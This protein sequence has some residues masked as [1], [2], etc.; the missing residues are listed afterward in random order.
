MAMIEEAMPRTPPT[1]DYPRVNARVILIALTGFWGCFVTLYTLRSALLYG[2]HQEASFVRRVAVACVGMALAWLIYR[3]LAWL[4]PSS[5]AP[6]IIWTA[7]MSMPAAI[8]FSA[9]NFLVFDVIAPIPGDT[10]AHGLPCTLHDAIVSIS[11]QT[12]NWSFVF[13]AWGLLYLSMVAAMQTRAADL[14]AATHREAAR[15]AEIRA[16]RYQINPHFLFNL[17]NALSTLVIRRQLSEAEALIGEI[18]RF[19]RYSLAADPVADAVLGDEI[20]M[21]ARYLEL[22][23]RR[24][25]SRLNIVFDVDEKVAAALTPSLILQPIVENAVKH[26]VGRTSSTV[27][28]AIRASEASGGRL[29]IVI[30]DNARPGDDGPMDAPDASAPTGLGI[31]LKNV[32]DRLRAR[33]GADTA[34]LAGPLPGGGYRV[35]LIMPLVLA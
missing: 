22:E 10:C 3:M 25:P 29:R 2:H 8:L 26:G 30:E 28:I 13:A 31:G 35:E 15:V 12:I 11:D 32:A 20:E 34:C 14:R 9:A 17:L 16:L 18:G 33:F 19:F 21:Q 27:T 23:R 5:L 1:D 4:R 6:K 7:A 24:F